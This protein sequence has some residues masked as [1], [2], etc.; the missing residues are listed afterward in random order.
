MAHHVDPV[1][2]HLH[3][4]TPRLVFLDAKSAIEFYQRAFG[5]VELDPPH[6]GPGGMVV[7][8]QIRIGDSVVY[9][10]DQGDNGGDAVSPSSVGGRVTAIMALN[11]PNVDEVW[12]RAVAAGCEV[13]HPL[14]DQFYGDRGGRVRDPYGHEWML[15]THI[16]DVDR[17]ELDRRMR[18][19]STEVAHKP[20]TADGGNPRPLRRGDRHRVWAPPPVSSS[21]GGVVAAAPGEEPQNR[22]NNDDPQHRVDNQSQH[23]GNGYD[24]DGNK[25]IEQHGASV[26]FCLRR[27]TSADRTDSPSPDTPPST[28]PNALLRRAI[29][30]YS[31]GLVATGT[32]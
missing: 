19:W 8:A 15:S 32:R 31:S 26:P 23:R 17:E 29:T 21:I 28:G 18:A 24:D 10:T 20:R 1:P 11:V 5:A 22:G 27:K 4:V 12:E 2:A 30:A 25:D 16:E 3:T 13:I 7:H 6:L 9:L 14:A